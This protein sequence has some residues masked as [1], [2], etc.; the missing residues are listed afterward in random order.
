[1]A[2]SSAYLDLKK[3]LDSKGVQLIA[4]SKTQSLSSIQALY[5]LGQRAFGENRVQELMEKQAQMPEDIQWHIIGQLQRNKVKFLVPFVTMIQSVDS[6][7]LAETID[8]EAS[9][10]GRRIDILLQVKIAL[11]DAKTGWDIK[12]LHE[13]L[14]L[15]SKMDH[16]RIRGIMGMGTFTSD[17]EVTRQEFHD[18]R[19]HYNEIRSAHFAT[20]DDFEILSMGMSGDYLLAIETGSTMVR[21]GSLLFR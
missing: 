1:M 21:I 19:S 2:S 6:L 18:L 15:L 13:A 3:H 5:D 14:P 9:K 16:V 7:R 11:E 4:V 8:K 20:S 17:Q 10:V 12:A